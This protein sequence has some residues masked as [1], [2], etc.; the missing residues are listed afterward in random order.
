M[1]SFEFIEERFGGLTAIQKAAIPKI[2]EGRNVIIL[3]PTGYGKCVGGD[4]TIITHEGP[5]KIQD[6]YLKQIK[7]NTLNE[8][9]K[10]GVAT[11]AV[12]RKKKSRLFL[13]KTGAGRSIKVTSDHK[14]LVSTQKGIE[15]RPL[16]KLRPGDYVACSKKLIL[17]DGI[18]EFTLP[19]LDGFLDS[20]AV[21]TSPSAEELYIKCKLKTGKGTRDMAKMLDCDR[22]T[23]QNA[24]QGKPVVARLIEKLAKLAGMNLHKI[25]VENIS[26]AAMHPMK[27][28]IDEEF[29]YFTGL[30]AG[31]GNFNHGNVIRLSTASQEIL[32]FVRR[33]C[34][35]IGLRVKK[36]RSKKYD[37]YICSKALYILLNALGISDR[38]RSQELLVPRIFF[39]NKTLLAR[40]LRGVFDTDGRI[41][42]RV[43]E[44]TSKSKQFIDDIA[45][46]LLCY[47]ILPITKEKKIKERTYYRLFIEKNSDLKIFH[48]K[49]GFGEKN[50]TRRLKQLIVNRKP[51]PNLDIIPNTSALLKACKAKMKIPYSRKPD[52]RLLES[53]IYNH[54][55]PSQKSLKRILKMFQKT[56]VKRP[57]EFYLLSKL[58]ASDIFWDRI[59]SIDYSGKDH[60]Y[61][62]TIP[63]TSNFIGNGIVLHNTEA[64]L[65]PVL[66][67]IRSEEKGICA[68]YITPL[69]SL[70]RDLLSRF[71]YWCDK[72]DVTRV[73]RH[74]DTPQSER[75]KHRKAPPHIMLTTVESLQALLL[76]KIMRKHLSNVRFVIVDEVHDIV[77]N[78]RGA[79]L[80]LSLERLAEIAK[81]QRI[82][83]SA[84]VANEME[85]G[86]MLFGER[87][88]EVV[89]AGKKR[90]MDIE[91][92]FHSEQ[93]KRFRIMKELSEKHRSLI[94]VN[95][96]SAAEEIGAWLRKNGAP[97][98][99]HHGSL[100]KDVRIATEERFKAGDTNSLLCT[101][102]LELGID[103]GDVELVV[104]YG[105]PHQ[106]F[107]LVQRV[108]RSGHSITK[109]PK[110]IILAT[111]FD[112]ELESEVIKSLAENE[113]IESKNVEAGALDVI[114]HQLVGLAFDFWG[115]D[116]LQAHK[117]LSR[118]GVY[119]ISYEKLRK[120]ALQL[121]SE[122]I[123]FYDESGDG[124]R[125]SIKPKRRAREYY[126]S[127]LSTIPKVKRYL[128]R[129][130]SSNRPIASLDEEFVMNLEPGTDFLSKGQAWQVIDITDKEVLASPGA[131]LDIAIPSWTGEEIP[132]SYEVAQNVG[133]MRRMKKG[134]TRPLPD[135]RTMVIE[136]V[137]DLV[138]VHSL[139][140]SKVNE[141]IARLFAQRLSELIGESVRT[142]SDPYRIMIKL[143]FAL[144]Q[145]HIL[146]TF[147]SIK[148]VRHELEKS[149]HNSSL[150]KFIFTHVG[151]LFGL[152]S[153]DAAVNQKFIDSMR[154]S[155]VYEESLRYIFSRY[156]DVERTDDIFRKIKSKEIGLVVDVR[157]EPSFFAEIGIQRA[158]AREAVG[159]FEPREKM[160]IA[161]K[162]HVL[163][164]IRSM[165]CMNC[166]A[167]RY[168]YLATVKD[169]D[170][171]CPRC[172]QKS[173]APDVG[174]KD[175]KEHAAALIRSYGKRALIA[176]SVYGIGPS[177]AARILRKL[178]KDENAFYL[179][180]IEAQKAFVKTKKYW[181]IK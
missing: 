79:Q 48:D 12:I 160:I 32:D 89:E 69:R 129:D 64:A 61:D 43:I 147:N 44:L 86:K 36:D 26:G 92:E 169:A 24:I 158:S 53:Y 101:S 157:E 37:Y 28:V 180:I 131:G 96:R 45:L 78:K 142:V 23:L 104:Q 128:L 121:Y 68:L 113:W 140:G 122:G 50:K 10:I 25:K 163:S 84:T 1:K 176:L 13:V 91:V 173:L 2:F 119:G 118:S 90:K 74:G 22:Q 178:H 71:H 153:E 15:W 40:F 66:E 172:S 149:V 3:A 139:F 29:A 109:L 80:S 110:G 135:D 111:D 115:L 21:K 155:V 103:I 144:N 143:P 137:K 132:V 62:A 145:K 112:D 6:A 82:G 31:D 120:I 9:F 72:L 49:I 138:I 52:Y 134:K 114:A 7:T 181:K 4:T 11:G 16:R 164:K 127:N 27:V 166:G 123:I 77:D 107:R 83:I 124:R 73:V 58:A 156:F 93:E 179:D 116:L 19:F 148:D 98:E 51:N 30:F 102:S 5:I 159:A 150:M 125:I 56:S 108:G 18:V 167:T 99:V 70:N 126:F 47:G 168:I 171:K 146:T 162:E 17:A 88:Y 151:R 34:N 95:T 161:L 39:R 46:A 54:R 38:N 60:V 8:D 33:F 130:V 65:L 152:L 94:F 20:I 106:V 154:Y 100:S 174:A 117:I 165:V 133:A 63:T 75:T 177:T 170:L 76:G 136:I 81:F 42:G 87:P 97:V 14:F 67:K 85:V 175:E 41:Y 105:S 59:S 141:G 55:N 57:P 35:R